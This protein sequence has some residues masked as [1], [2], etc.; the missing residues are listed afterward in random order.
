VNAAVDK[1]K[2]SAEVHL[3]SAHDLVP[4]KQ[5][6]YGKNEPLTWAAECRGKRRAID[7]SGYGPG[8]RC[9]D[10]PGGEEPDPM[11]EAPNSHMA[12]S[13]GIEDIRPADSVRLPAGPK[14]VYAYA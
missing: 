4:L 5:V 3:L 8:R 7:D 10:D 9:D 1:E 11:F 12:S 2:E 13:V 14:Q 6:G